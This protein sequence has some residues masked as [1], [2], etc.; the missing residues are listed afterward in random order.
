MFYELTKTIPYPLFF[1]S[2]VVSWAL[3]GCGSEQERRG[4][5]A[6][7]LVTILHRLIARRQH[8]LL[9]ARWPTGSCHP[10]RQLQKEHLI[11]VLFIQWRYGLESLLRLFGWDHRCDI[12]LQVVTCLRLQFE[13]AARCM[14]LMLYLH[15][16]QFLILS[17]WGR[18]W[19]A[20]DEIIVGLCCSGIDCWVNKHI[21]T[22]SRGLLF[23]MVWGAW[24]TSLLWLWIL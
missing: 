15:A 10:T 5:R 4:W 16:F 12:R 19:D 23:A 11:K 17:V 22:C 13:H 2:S 24:F 8:M 21:W 7:V 20:I 6:V 9:L 14:I 18:R 3:W 1:S